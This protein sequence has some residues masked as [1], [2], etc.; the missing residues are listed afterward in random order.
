[1][2]YKNS[3]DNWYKSMKT[4]L[5]YPQGKDTVK[6]IVAEKV[7]KGETRTYL[8]I[9]KWY[10]DEDGELKPGKGFAAPVTPFQMRQIANAILKESSELTAQMLKDNPGIAVDGV[11]MSD[12]F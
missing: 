4:L 12:K 1:M 2:P 6:V 11:D 10:E 8:D 5:E 3:E 7:V 9:R